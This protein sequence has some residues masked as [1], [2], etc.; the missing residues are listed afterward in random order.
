MKWSDSSILLLWLLWANGVSLIILNVAKGHI[1][2]IR[3]SNICNFCTSQV[4]IGCC[5][6]NH[7]RIAS[8]L[9]QFYC[10]SL[11]S[12][13]E[14]GKIRNCIL[15]HFFRLEATR[16]WDYKFYFMTKSLLSL[17]VVQIIN[18]NPHINTKIL[19]QYLWGLLTLATDVAE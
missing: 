6:V 12:A 11:Q 7:K 13:K 2:S 10:Q 9:Q 14:R 17:L 15:R 5:N 3:A 19:L 18:H 4:K 16:K 8:Y 1:D